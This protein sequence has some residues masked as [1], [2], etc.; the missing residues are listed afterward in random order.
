VMGE[1]EEF[2]PSVQVLARLNSLTL[3]V[4]TFVLLSASQ[5]YQALR[6]GSKDVQM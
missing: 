6:G 4:S 3:P 5:S 1:R 2:E